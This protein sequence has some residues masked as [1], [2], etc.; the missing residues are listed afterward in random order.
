MAALVH[1][2]LT[3]CQALSSPARRTVPAQHGV[4]SRLTGTLR[5]W[6]RRARERQEL[7]TLSHRELRDLPVSASDVWHEI[8]QPF[9]RASGHY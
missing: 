8:R 6:Q 7:A 1:P 5:Q 4:L 3:N 2:S 9:W